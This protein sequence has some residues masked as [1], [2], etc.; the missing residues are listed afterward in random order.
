MELIEGVSLREFI[1]KQ[2]KTNNLLSN[3]DL[4][5]LFSQIIDGMFAIN[6]KVVHRDIKPENILYSQSTIK[7][8]DFGLAKISEDSTRTHSFKGSGTY[9]YM[10]P[11]A[12]TLET[13]TKDM[14]VYSTGLL[15]YELATLKMPFIEYNPNSYEDWKSAHLYKQLKSVKEI[16]KSC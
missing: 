15:F 12:W 14:D 16:F 2:A 6:Q 9:P 3:E 8:T 10:A 7:I 13:N 5:N 1:S 11:E 4:L